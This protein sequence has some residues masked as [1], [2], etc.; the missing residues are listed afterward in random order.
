MKTPLYSV[1]V[2]LSLTSN[3][4]AAKITLPAPDEKSSVKNYSK[5]I[6]WP[7]GKMPKAPQGFVVSMFAKDL[8]S[9]RWMY[10]LPNGD[11]LVAEAKTEEKNPVK[12]IGS[13]VTGA[14]K[15]ANK[16]D[17]GNRIT[18]FRDANRDGTYETREIFLA[19]LKQ[20]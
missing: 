3:S 7:Q 4:F 18:L 11:V 14:S 1:L 16:D 9:P 8:K 12:K 6:G 17:A 19:D 5:V 20:P 15:S 13:I 2:L 10:A